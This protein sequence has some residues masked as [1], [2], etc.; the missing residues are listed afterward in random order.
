MSLFAIERL[1]T[2]LQ[3]CLIG[4]TIEHHQQLGSTMIRARQLAALAETRSGTLVIAEE[5]TA[6]RGRRQR[7]WEAPLGEALL[8][9][10]ILKPPLPLALGLLP[11]AIGSAIVQALTAF[12][13]ALQGQVGLK[14]PND[15]LL[16]TGPATAGKVAG[17]LIETSYQTPESALVIVG[18]GINVNQAASA[19][20]VVTSGATN[21]LSL[22]L[23][24]QPCDQ[25][26]LD[27]T[28]L[29]IQLCQTLADSLYHLPNPETLWLTWRQMLWT[30]HQP[31]TIYEQTYE[32][33]SGNR[34]SFTGTA[35]DVTPDG[36][37]VVV[38]QQGVRRVF[39]A[40]D[41]T[42]RPA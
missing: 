9:S 3:H 4:H 14:W 41:V 5:Q 30:L 31:V 39:A 10:L 12:A 42:L 37:L 26:P 25:T 29:L 15:V 32:A 2:Q 7:Q 27:R 18:I 33:A 36:C 34:P 28:A 13:P 21:P 1:R 17:I 6:G 11:M 20:P 16:G 24:L 38:N 23:Y 35:V 22:R 8:L 40:G 19:L